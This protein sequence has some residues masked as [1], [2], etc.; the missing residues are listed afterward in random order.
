MSSSYGRGFH[1]VD[2]AQTQ[3]GRFDN[4]GAHGF[5]LEGAWAARGTHEHGGALQKQQTVWRP[6]GSLARGGG[7]G[8]SGQPRVW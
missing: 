6:V 8:G 1:G 5:R 4:G 3:G 2:M 7:R